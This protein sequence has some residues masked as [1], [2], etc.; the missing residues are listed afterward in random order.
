MYKVFCQ[1]VKSFESSIDKL[2]NHRFL[3]TILNGEGVFDDANDV[4]KFLQWIDVTN[5]QFT[6]NNL[7][8][9]TDWAT[10]AGHNSDNGV[11]VMSCTLSRRISSMGEYRGQIII[12]SLKAYDAKYGVPL[13]KTIIQQYLTANPRRALLNNFTTP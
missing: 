4:E 13:A 9:D 8:A 3:R 5:V 12:D 7:N 10:L 1:I 2:N 6:I 11:E